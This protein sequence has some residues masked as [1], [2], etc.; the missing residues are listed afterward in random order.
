MCVRVCVRVALAARGNSFASLG[1]HLEALSD[2]RHVLNAFDDTKSAI[3]SYRA[4]AKVKMQMRE[5]KSA[6]GDLKHVLG[7]DNELMSIVNPLL[8]ECRSALALIDCTDGIKKLDLDSGS[9][10]EVDDQSSLLL[11]SRANVYLD[12]K[13]YK[14]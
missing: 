7:L 10:K 8:E 12:Q 13:R 14:K 3:T 11:F 6:M 4:Q 9:D 5:Y 2:Y 1:E